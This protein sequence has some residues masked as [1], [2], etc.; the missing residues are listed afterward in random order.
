[1]ADE[2]IGGGGRS[3]RDNLTKICFQNQDIDELLN[4]IKFYLYSPLE[5]LLCD[6]LRSRLEFLLCPAAM[7]PLGGG[8]LGKPSL[9]GNKKLII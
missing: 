3:G 1:M 5:F 4:L 8:I 9:I 7:W 2:G 6:L